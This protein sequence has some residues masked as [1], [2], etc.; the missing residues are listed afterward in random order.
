MSLVALLVLA[1]SS[2]FPTV[3]GLELFGILVVL[4]VVG[5]V[6]GVGFLRESGYSWFYDEFC[7]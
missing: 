1:K 7:V 3:V 4:W 5:V 6:D 2:L